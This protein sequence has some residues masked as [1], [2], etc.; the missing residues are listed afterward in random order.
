LY[1]GFYLAIPKKVMHFFR[2]IALNTKKHIVR[3]HGNCV[4][5][6]DSSRRTFKP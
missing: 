3:K 1:F 6:H 5:M 4:F 2:P